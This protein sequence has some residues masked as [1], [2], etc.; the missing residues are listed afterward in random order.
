MMTQA[1]MLES[2]MDRLRRQVGQAGHDFNNLLT[3]IRGRSELLL[4]RLDAGD[5]D[6][7]DIR[8]DIQEIL[9]VAT[10]GD[11]LAQHLVALSRGERG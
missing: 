5:P 9:R 10:E 4:F 7:G 11:S 1:Q 2:D 8:R 6:C 3:K